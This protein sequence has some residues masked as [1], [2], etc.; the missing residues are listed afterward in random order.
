MKSVSSCR[1]SAHD[2]FDL[3]PNPLTHLSAVTPRPRASPTPRRNRFAER[4][5]HVGG[6]CSRSLPTPWRNLSGSRPRTP[7]ESLSQPAPWDETGRSRDDGGVRKRFRR[8]AGFIAG[9]FRRGAGLCRSYGTSRFRRGAE[10]NSCHLGAVLG[11]VLLRFG[12]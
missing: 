1:T 10:Q 2:S 12:E 8:G 11:M 7:T 4:T 9:G 3:T 6:I 5:P